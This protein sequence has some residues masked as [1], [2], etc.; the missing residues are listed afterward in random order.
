MLGLKVLWRAAP[1]IPQNGKVALAL[2]LPLAALF[3]GFDI[4]RYDYAQPQQSTYLVLVFL[5]GLI[6]MLASFV[7]AIAW[8]RS[9]L[10]PRA[11]ELGRVLRRPPL[12]AYGWRALVLALVVVVLVTLPVTLLSSLL[13]SLAY[14]ATTTGEIKDG[15]FWLGFLLGEYLGPFLR[16]FLLTLIGIGLPGHAIGQPVPLRESLRF[17]LRNAHHVLVAVLI[18]ELVLRLA[19]NILDEVLIS[20][21]PT[22]RVALFLGGYGLLMWLSILIAVG[23]ITEFFRELATRWIEPE[24]QNAAPV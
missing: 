3:I 15:Y 19:Y 5:S 24:T 23:T 18:A 2:G 7:L 11:P 1:A 16:I 4:W 9:L 10:D 22:L 17:G 8:H 20:A 21:G 13:V 14:P 12:W 6:L